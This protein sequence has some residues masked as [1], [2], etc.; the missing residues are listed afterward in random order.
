M[1]SRRGGRIIN[2][3]SGAGTMSSPYY[4]SY[5][6]GKTAL[7]RFTECVALEAKAHGVVLF[8]IS[9][10]T[11]RTAMANYSLTSPEGKKWL[12]WFAQIIERQIDVPAERPAQLVLE[13]AYGR[14][15]ALSGRMISIFD[16]L[17]LLLKNAAEIERQNLYS[18]KM[19]KLQVGGG[20][21]ALAAV[22]DAAR[23]AAE[24]KK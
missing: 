9:P 5:V 10:G 8:A 11:V 17:D 7:I 4:S 18:L 14:A 23:R 21:P 3:A 15:D 1:I 2:V 22:L 20:N 19:D 24:T 16:D 13:L 12:P 6:A